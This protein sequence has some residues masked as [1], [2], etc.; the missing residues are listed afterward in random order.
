MLH[1]T[2]RI[3]LDRWPLRGGVPCLD[4]ANTEAY[5]GSR[6]EMDLLQSYDMLVAWSL[7]AGVLQPAEAGPLLHAAAAA[8]EAAAQVLS[9]VR[10]LRQA[11]HVVMQS[12]AHQTEPPVASLATL[13]AFLVESQGHN[14]IVRSNEGYEARFHP[15]DD[16]ALP[17]WRLTDSAARLLLSPEHHRVRECPGHDCGWL[18]LDTTRN[19]SRRWCDSADCGNKARV[20]AYTRRKREAAH[21]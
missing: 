7:I 1:T 12:V 13:N 8:P 21:A 5:R 2:P 10:E 6:H 16:M 11:I 18:F 9:R 19:H 3:A 14:Q 20:R 15:E 17:I 4:L